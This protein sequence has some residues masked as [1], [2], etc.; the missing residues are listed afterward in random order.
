MGRSEY[1]RIDRCQLGCISKRVFPKL[2]INGRVGISEKCS[3]L[4][5]NVCRTRT[6]RYL[7]LLSRRYW[8][9]ISMRCQSTSCFGN[10]ASVV[11]GNLV[12]KSTSHGKMNYHSNW[13]WGSENK[14]GAMYRGLKQ[15]RRKRQGTK[16]SGPVTCQTQ[17]F[18]V[19]GA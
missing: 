9:A 18:I 17:S 12:E 15:E 8:S 7:Q 4:C 13:T 16:G 1:D 10:E 3:S 5:D 11:L 6:Q 14:L 2:D 19:I